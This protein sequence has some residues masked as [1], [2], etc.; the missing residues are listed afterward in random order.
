MGNDSK[1]AAAESVYATISDLASRFNV[2]IDAGELAELAV[3]R[4]FG[5]EE[6]AA[7][8]DLFAYLA[9][10]HHQATIEMLLRLG[11]LPKKAH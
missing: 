3:R 1:E 4:D 8:R 11:R 10:R 2:G 5:D 6:L 9:D 7:I